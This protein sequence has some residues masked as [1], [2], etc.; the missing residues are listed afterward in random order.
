M[1]NNTASLTAPLFVSVVFLL[2]GISR[3]LLS[4]TS[5][6]D[7][8]SMILY[9]AIFELFVFAIPA[10]FFLK[11]KD[12]NFLEYSKIKKI[13]FSDMPFILS[14][15]ATF[16]FGAVIILYLQRNFLDASADAT[17]LIAPINEDVS[18]FSVF[19]YY[20]LIPALSEELFFRSIIIS[21]YSSYTGPVAITI[22]ALFFAMLHFS[23]AEFP[24]YFFSGAVLG[25][26]TFVTGSVFPAIIIH[27]LNNTVTVF[28]GQW[29]T[30]FL[31]ESS[32]SVILAFILV[33][34]FLASLLSL[35]STMEE[36]YEKR[37][38]MYD[39]GIV[40]GKRR[41]SLLGMAK[42]GIVEKRVKVN[43]KT[44]TNPFLSPT[45][46]MAVVLYIL[47]TLNVI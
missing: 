43:Q 41:E 33:V 20:V 32:S 22:S 5:A 17:S 23:F 21:E 44:R 14:A 13:T 30:S 4:Y 6:S 16:V 34:L 1:K 26:L 38:I 7:S 46:F 3:R 8:E 11:I 37:S 28:F 31:S 19:L 25:I 39:R 24:F 15:A 27:I 12:E 36:I 10:A 42:A 47:I 35:L 45:L 9:A 40:P 2:L 29:L 18:L